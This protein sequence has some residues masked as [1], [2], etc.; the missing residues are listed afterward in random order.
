MRVKATFFSTVIFARNA[1]EIIR[2]IIEGGHELASHGYYHSSF[3]TVTLASSK[4]ALQELS[5]QEIKGYRMAA[6]E[7]C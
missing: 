5:G 6:D 2:R 1:P 7:T 3:E 4:I